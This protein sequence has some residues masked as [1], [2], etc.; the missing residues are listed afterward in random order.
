[1]VTGNVFGKLS[2]EI[3]YSIHM[4]KSVCH[5]TDSPSSQKASTH[6]VFVSFHYCVVVVTVSDKFYWKTSLWRSALPIRISV[7]FP[8]ENSL[9]LRKWESQVESCLL[10]VIMLYFT[11]PLDLQR[12]LVV[13][14]DTLVRGDSVW[15]GLVRKWVK[16]FKLVETVAPKWARLICTVVLCLSGS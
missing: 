7:N 11:P 10:I 12:W 15:K 16:K 6:H 5:P 9:P 3:N 14:I 2:E 4:W 13:W 1:M 8:P